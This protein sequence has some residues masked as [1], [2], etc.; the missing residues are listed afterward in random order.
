MARSSEQ[1]QAP[2]QARLAGLFY[3]AVIVFGVITL[4][5]RS[6]VVVRGD[7]AASVANMAAHEF[8][9]RM[10]LLAEIAAA[11]AYLIVVALLFRVMMPAGRQ[12]SG[13][14]A[15]F[16]LAG[17]TAGA[18]AVVPLALP[19][20]AIA[21]ANGALSAAELASLAI[22]LYSFSFKTALIFFGCY[23]LL[24]GILTIRA[25]F[26][27]SFLGALLILSGVS[28]LT[29][30]IA[31]YVST[32]AARAVGTL[33]LAG[34]GLGEILFTGWLLIFGVNGETWRRQACAE[35]SRYTGNA[36]HGLSTATSRAEPI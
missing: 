2:R 1:F 25:A 31:T 18:I 4:M 6:G 5:L 12:L 10:S 8:A 22:G 26:L 29:T 3:L 13:L 19:M 36:A 28:W 7:A 35:V 11:L 15:G 34:G 16:G 30:G 33:A 17:C 21:G 9:F 27:P 32:D 20:G 24:L 23:C 14:T